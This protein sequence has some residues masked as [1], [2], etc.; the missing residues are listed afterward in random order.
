MGAD[1][2]TSTGSYVANRVSDKITQL[3]DRIY[4]CRSGSAAG[5][6]CPRQS[7]DELA[8]LSGLPS[9]R[10]CCADT[11]ALTDYVRRFVAEHA[12]EKGRTPTVQ[13][14]SR[15]FRSLA[16]E[17][18]DRLMAG[19][20]AVVPPGWG[21]CVLTSLLRPQASLLR[22]GMRLMAAQST[23]SPWEAPA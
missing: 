3:H 23:K 13:A 10:P 1:S 5:T 21:G 19:A 9:P 4:V 8:R 20:L 15:L 18:K 6:P 17:N 2:R 11:Q 22:A 14:A 7:S 12:I 16:Y